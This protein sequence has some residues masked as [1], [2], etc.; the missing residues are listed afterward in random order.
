MSS[1][2]MGKSERSGLRHFWQLDE[3]FY[4]SP[5]TR[6]AKMTIHYRVNKKDKKAW[7]SLTICRTIGSMSAVLTEVTCTKCI[8]RVTWS[9]DEFEICR[10]NFITL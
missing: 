4:T 3:T 9:K 1:C 7:G 5:T 6:K 2:A 10:E 8:R